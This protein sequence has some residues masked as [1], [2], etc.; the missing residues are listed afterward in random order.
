MTTD[1][2]ESRKSIGDSASPGKASNAPEKTMSPR[3]RTALRSTDT[4]MHRAIRLIAPTKK[5]TC[6][7]VE[8][9]YAAT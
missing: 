8:A 6:R 1:P 3:T 4:P 7:K 9:P 5:I 2:R